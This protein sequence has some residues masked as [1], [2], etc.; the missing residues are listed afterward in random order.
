MIETPAAVCPYVGL[1][2]FNESDAKYFFGRENDTEVV[3]TNLRAA[4]LTVFYGASGVG[5]S[6]VIRAGVVPE[7][8]KLTRLSTLPDEPPV[9]FTGR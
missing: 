7:L 5:K 4:R 9:F 3:A 1:L 6:S 2:P 8:Q